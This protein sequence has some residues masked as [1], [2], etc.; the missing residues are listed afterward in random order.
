VLCTEVGSGR[1]AVFMDGPLADPAPWATDPNILAIPT[2]ITAM[3][4]RASAA[5]PFLFPAVRIGERYYVD[6]G[7]RMN[8]PL[9]PA[10][11]TRLRSPAD[12][13]VEHQPAGPSR[14]PRSRIP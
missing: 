6:G 4:V 13:R 11:A 5:I 3:H 1:V 8:T 10:P 2:E 12:D 9:S 7:L 14:R